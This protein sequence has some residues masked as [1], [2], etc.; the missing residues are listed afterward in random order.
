MYK[1]QIAKPDSVELVQ[2]LDRK[3]IVFT[4]GLNAPNATSDVTVSKN[5]FCDN[6]TTNQLTKEYPCFSN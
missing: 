5:D 4:F 3:L 2:Q 1:G 6:L